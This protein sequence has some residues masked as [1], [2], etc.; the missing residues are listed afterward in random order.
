MQCPHH[1]F[2]LITNKNYRMSVDA[3]NSNKAKSVLNNFIK[4]TVL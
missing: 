3:K 1:R 2:P 4:V